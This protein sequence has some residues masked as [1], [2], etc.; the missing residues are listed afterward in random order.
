MKEKA[1][2]ME[3]ICIGFNGIPVLKD[4]DFSLDKGEVCGLVGKN[5]AGKS[6]LLKIIQGLYHAGS[7]KVEIFGAD[8]TKEISDKSYGLVGMIFQ[9]LSLIPEMSVLE[10]LFLNNEIKARGMIY[11]REE[12]QRAAEFMQKYGVHISVDE[13][14]KNLGSADKQMVEICKAIL[15]QKKILLMDEPTASLDN[16]QADKFY[17]MVKQLKE[18]G[19]SIILITHHLQEIM[20]NCDSIAVIRDGIMTLHDK[21]ANVS[22]KKM[23]E[24]MLGGEETDLAFSRSISEIK[25]EQP[26]LEV[27][28]ITTKYIK[29]PLSFKIYSG[30]VVGMAGLKG[31]GRTEVFRAVFGLDKLISGEIYID[32][33]KVEIKSTTDAVNAGIYLIP[34]S[35]RFQGLSVEHSIKFNIELPL[36][37][38]LTKHLFIDDA[39]SSRIVDDYIE[40]IHIKSNSRND[41]V[42]NL[43]GGNQQK[44]VISKALATNPKVLLMDDPTYGVDVGAKTEI[45]KIINEFK[46]NGGAVILAS[47]EIEEVNQNCN[48]IFILKGRKL[49]GELSN[50]D[51]MTVTQDKL[52]EEIQ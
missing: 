41:L 26:I 13:K 34:E 48:R 10:N 29:D 4:I 30:E 38:K 49:T 44:V 45:M 28:N 16:E 42:K 14:V 36:L 47:S 51:Y 40:K 35:R 27:K 18:E 21:T 23:I 24:A 46:M 22:M 12:K 9:E 17:R 33:K 43:S 39:K 8:T 1:L 11:V 6:T 3:K 32:G 15:K 19:I 5:G 37:G 2:N 31:C 25:Y 50:E 52:A 20:D 7:G